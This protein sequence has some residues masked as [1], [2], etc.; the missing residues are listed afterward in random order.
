MAQ[1]PGQN[2]N[3]PGAASYP[4]HHGKVPPSS[5]PSQRLIGEI[6]GARR[7]F[8]S[9]EGPCGLGEVLWSQAGLALAP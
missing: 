9:L 8:L 1:P 4:P 2:S 5:A 6:P 7:A 3:S